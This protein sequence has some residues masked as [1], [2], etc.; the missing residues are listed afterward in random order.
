MEAMSMSGVGDHL[1]EADR[2][3]V[4]GRPEEAFA[5]AAAVGMAGRVIAVGAAGRAHAA[6]E[7]RGRRAGWY[8]VEFHEEGRA[9]P[10]ADG[11]IDAV[12]ISGPPGPSRRRGALLYEIARVLRAGGRLLV[13]DGSGATVDFSTAVPGRT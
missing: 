7:E 13:A 4:L 11:S 10:A 9:L 8:G 3:L 1:A 5:A 2:V 6:A 12:V